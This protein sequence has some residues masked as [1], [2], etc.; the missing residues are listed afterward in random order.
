MAGERSAP[1][2]LPADSM[3]G[4]MIAA[5]DWSATPLGP[6]EGWPAPLRD[7]VTMLLAAPLPMVLFWGPEL[8]A[9]YNDPYSLAI[10]D[11]VLQLIAARAAGVVRGGDMV[12]RLGGEEFGILMP[13]ASLDEAAIVAERLREAMEAT[14]DGAESLPTVTISVGIAAR[15]RQDNA[16][17][18][19]TSADVAL[20]AAKGAGRNRVRVAA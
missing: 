13:G 10:G 11:R 3:L 1:F 4:A 2:P 7:T 16:A 8:I 6:I 12:G 9:L 5:Y 20:Y 18:L 15:E 17:A 14:G 19:L